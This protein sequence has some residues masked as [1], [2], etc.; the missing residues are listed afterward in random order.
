MILIY[1]LSPTIVV[2]WDE[3]LNQAV[4]SGSRD[5]VLKVCQEKYPDYVVADP[6]PV[7]GAEEDH[8]LIAARA[9][10]QQREGELYKKG[11]SR[12]TPEQKRAK[13]RTGSSN[14]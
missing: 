11:R 10:L 1:Q 12:T 5:A 13:S 8:D 9:S 14:R 2:A 3:I 6:E 4:A 7:L